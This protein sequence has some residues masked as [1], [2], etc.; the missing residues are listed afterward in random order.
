MY[1]IC[2]GEHCSP[3]S[4]LRIL[5]RRTVALP[6]DWI[7][8]TPEQLCSVIRND[9][10]GFHENLKL[11]ENK[12]YIIDSYELEFPHDYPTIKNEHNEFRQIIEGYIEDSWKEIIPQIQQKYIRRITRFHEIMKSSEP[13]IALF[14]GE[15]SN[16]KEFKKLFLEKYNKT[17]IYYVILSEEIISG[18]EA[19]ELMKEQI[20]MC[21]PEEIIIDE[22]GNFFID[23]IA[24]ANLWN[25]A[26]LK[27]SKEFN[28]Q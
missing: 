1:Y 22:N 12:E 9:F 17:N 7:R 3:A 16:I 21:D 2:L 24:Q 25:D 5:N 20:S 14:I 18:I 4:A 26:I 19:E 8:S 11:S 15:V 23:K 27:I 10:K 13:V 6:F 28:L